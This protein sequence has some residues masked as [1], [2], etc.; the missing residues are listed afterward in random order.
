[1]CGGGGGGGGGGGV[2]KFFPL[3][4]APVLTVITYFFFMCSPYGKKKNILCKLVSL[5]CKYLLVVR[6]LRT[7]VM[8][9][10][11]MRRPTDCAME[12]GQVF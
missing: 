4:I 5:Y 1:M 3:R 6:I 7:C 11:P 8:G 2:S 10:T 12:T 9:A